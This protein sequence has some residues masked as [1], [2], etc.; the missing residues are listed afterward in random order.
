MEIKRFFIPSEKIDK[1]CAVIDN[2]EFYHIVKVLRLKKGFKI[3]VCTGDGKDYYATIDKIHDG[4]LTAA[5]H[6]TIVNDTELPFKLTMLQAIPSKDKLEIIVQKAVETGVSVF[7]PFISTHVN[8]SRVN[9]ERLEKIIKEAAKQCGAN[10][11]M[12]IIPPV[13][14]EEAVNIAKKSFL[15]IIAYEKETD[16]RLC[17]LSERFKTKDFSAAFFVGPEG[18]FTDEEAS[19][20]K[21]N[22]IAAITLGKRILRCETAGVVVSA[23]IASEYNRNNPAKGSV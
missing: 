6:E 19:C 23:L 22:G 21:D 2:D 9:I 10:K 18:G 15:P 17:K 12:R 14:F 11:L 1:Q 5:I 7:V 20:A 4:Y 3:V 16:G 8:D 13:D